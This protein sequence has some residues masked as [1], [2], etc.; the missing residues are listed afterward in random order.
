[1]DPELVGFI[2]G[3]LSSELGQDVALSTDAWE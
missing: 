1:M 2:Q 3:P